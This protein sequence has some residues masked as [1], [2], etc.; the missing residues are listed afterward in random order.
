MP[1]LDTFVRS[2]IIFRLANGTLLTRWR[3]T[4]E[5]DRGRELSEDVVQSGEKIAAQVRRQILQSGDEKLIS[6]ISQ[7]PE[8]SWGHLKE[9]LSAA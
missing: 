8:E 7:L 2:P 9:I 3:S 6:I 4:C 5:S 1:T